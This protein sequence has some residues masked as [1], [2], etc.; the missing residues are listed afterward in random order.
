MLEIDPDYV[1]LQLFYRGNDKRE[2]VFNMLATRDF[3]KKLNLM[4][5]DRL[6]LT[7]T[8]VDEN[9]WVCQMGDRAS[10]VNL[11]LQV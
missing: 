2:F 8:K 10:K 6:T 7:I 1:G 9:D 5:G 11:V 3:A 4:V